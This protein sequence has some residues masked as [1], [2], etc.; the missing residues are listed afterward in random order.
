MLFSKIGINVEKTF[1]KSAIDTFGEADDVIQNSLEK[2][3][4][5]REC[6]CD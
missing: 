2:Y 6:P 3:M 4:C 1:F 5:K